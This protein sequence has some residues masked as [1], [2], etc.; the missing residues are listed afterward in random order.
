MLAAYDERLST[1]IAAAEEIL[2][3]RSGGPVAA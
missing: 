2:A 1:L 3:L